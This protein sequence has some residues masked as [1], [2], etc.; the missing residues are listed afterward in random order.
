ME[1]KKI[2]LVLFGG[3]LELSH[4]G[5]QESINRREGEARGEGEESEGGWAAHT[6]L[7]I[8]GE[9]ASLDYYTSWLA[10]LYSRLT[11]L[12]TSLRRRV[13]AEWCLVSVH[14]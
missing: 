4:V 13:G 11:Q 12:G 1:N 2:W 8:Y 10:L 5:A 6:S 14:A 3:V 9:S 7:S